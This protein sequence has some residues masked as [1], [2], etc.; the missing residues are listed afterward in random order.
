MM[1]GRDRTV[2]LLVLSEKIVVM[3]EREKIASFG[4]KKREEEG[5]NGG[6]LF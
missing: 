2:E 3:R 1:T 5:K 4:T 6:K